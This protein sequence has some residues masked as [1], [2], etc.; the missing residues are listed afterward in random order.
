MAINFQEG[1]YLFYSGFTVYLTI[2]SEYV[3][4]FQTVLWIIENYIAL[5]LSCIQ[6]L[7]KS[8]DRDLTKLGSSPQM[9]NQKI[10]FESIKL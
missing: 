1:R 7:V 3:R 9:N 5:Y 10:K 4:T 2:V 8:T 6:R